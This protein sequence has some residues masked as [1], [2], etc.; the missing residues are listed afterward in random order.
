MIRLPT[1][2]KLY[3]QDNGKVYKTERDNKT[4]ILENVSDARGDHIKEWNVSGVSEPTAEQLAT[5][6][7][8]GKTDESLRNV[9]AKRKNE[10][11]TLR[12][13]AEAYTE[14]EIGGNSTKWDAY[15]INYNKVRT[16][17]PK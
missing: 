8:A 14:K 13:F 2:I 5:Y 12:D 4:F 3:L 15:V 16:E 10:Y 7:S 11:P 9:N 17:N 6:E 1:K